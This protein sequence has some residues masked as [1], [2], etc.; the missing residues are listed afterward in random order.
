MIQIK[1][2]KLFNK[3]NLGFT[4]VELIVV[5]A[6]IAVL[7]SIGIA[8]FV[9]SSRNASLQTAQD[10]IVSM[11]EVAKSRSN[12]QTAP[13][14]PGS[15]QGSIRGYGV[16]FATSNTVCIAVICSD[17]PTTLDPNCDNALET[18]NLP[19][20]VIITNTPLP[21]P[22]YMPILKGRFDISDAVEINIQV[23]GTNKERLI[24]VNSSGV[25]ARATPTP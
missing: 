6:V 1:K 23:E 13:T 8:S 16:V 24:I 9:E 21:D 11:L 22:I 15:C 17:Y 25:V 2:L 5:L 12:S 4:L 10:K 7:S 19:E 20:G 18:Y 3:Q 14:T